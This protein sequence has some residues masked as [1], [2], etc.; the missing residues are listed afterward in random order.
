MAG[1]A[2]LLFGNVNAVVAENN[3]LSN[4]N[5]TICEQW[6]NTINF[7]ISKRTSVMQNTVPTAEK[8][9]IREKEVIVKIRCPYCKNPYNET[10]DKCPYC[11]ARA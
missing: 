6:A 9:I 5:K 1:A 10:L 7:L 8:E 2:G 3:A 4:Q 11:G